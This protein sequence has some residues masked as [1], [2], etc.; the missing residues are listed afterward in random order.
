MLERKRNF[1]EKILDN[2][3][4]QLSVKADCDCSDH[5]LCN[6]IG[7]NLEPIVIENTQNNSAA[8]ILE[9]SSHMEIQ[10]LENSCPSVSLR[11]LQ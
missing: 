6:S 11:Q 3:D 8:T 1:G 5:E 9:Q 4:T 10:L 7:F 2:K